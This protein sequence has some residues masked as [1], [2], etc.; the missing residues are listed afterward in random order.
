V[1]EHSQKP[2]LLFLRGGEAASRGVEKLLLGGWRSCFSGGGEADSRGSC[3]TSSP[4]LFNFFI[5]DLDEELE[6]TLTKFADGTKLGGGVDA[7]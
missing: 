6:Y 4:V 7:P 5:N 3:L 1:A 2:N